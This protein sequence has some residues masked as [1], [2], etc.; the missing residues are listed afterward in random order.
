MQQK[1]RDLATAQMENQSKET[2]NRLLKKNKWDEVP[3]KKEKE[4]Y[5]VYVSTRYLS[6]KL[7]PLG[8]RD[9]LNAKITT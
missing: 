3:L 1:N 9:A 5:G 2:I 7:A 6:A 8:S 4:H